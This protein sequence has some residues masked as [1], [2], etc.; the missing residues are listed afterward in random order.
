MTEIPQNLEEWA[1]EYS[2]F[3]CDHPGE[4]AELAIKAKTHF[5]EHPAWDHHGVIWHDGER[6]VERVKIYYVEQPLVYGDTL[7][8]VFESVNELYGRE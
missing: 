7:K 4:E 8:E 2:N 6:F 3:D 5:I 1:A